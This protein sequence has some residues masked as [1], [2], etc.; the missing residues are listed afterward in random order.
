MAV[1]V[2]K[3][4]VIFFGRAKTEKK[5]AS[6]KKHRARK[7][8]KKIADEETKPNEAKTMAKKKKT[9]TRTIFCSPNCD[10]ALRKKKWDLWKSWRFFF[11]FIS[12]WL[13]N[14]ISR[15]YWVS[16][17]KC[18]SSRSASRNVRECEDE[19]MRVFRNKKK[20]ARA[21]FFRLCGH[22]LCRCFLAFA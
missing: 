4:L 12:R 20:N 21:V 9:P 15:S 19:Q 6:G 5:S 18:G 8:T 22:N 1:G 7:K 17:T 2:V 16:D 3:N 14:W 11:V 10:H 13:W